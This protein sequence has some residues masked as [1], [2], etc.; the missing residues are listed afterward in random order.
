MGQ[1]T[2]SVKGKI[3]IFYILQTVPYSLGHTYSTL[4]CSA[5]LA[6]DS[7]QISDMALF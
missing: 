5:K 7:M 6:T 2:L 1:E 4:I 3:V